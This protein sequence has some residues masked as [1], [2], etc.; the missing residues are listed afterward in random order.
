MSK[1][2]IEIHNE[3]DSLVVTFDGCVAS[4]TINGEKKLTTTYSES[5]NIDEA[6]RK[7]T[8]ALIAESKR[9]S[10]VY[11]NIFPAFGREFKILVSNILKARV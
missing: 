2:N 3:K 6:A 9:P 5:L 7:L 10:S 4:V 1:R 8:K 11:A